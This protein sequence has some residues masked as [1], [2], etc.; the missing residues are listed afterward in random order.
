MANKYIYNIDD[1]M[2]NEL[3]GDIYKLYNMPEIVNYVHNG[4]PIPNKYKKLL[5]RNISSIYSNING[6]ISLQNLLSNTLKYCF[7]KPT[8]KN[9][10][11]TKQ[12]KETIMRIKIN[13]N[14]IKQTTPNS[15]D[16]LIKEKEI[17]MFNK[18]I[19][20]SNN[21]IENNNSIKTKYVNVVE[22]SYNIL[23]RKDN[24]PKY[25]YIEICNR[26][27]VKINFEEHFIRDYNNERITVKDGVIKK[28]FTNEID[29]EDAMI[30]RQQF[31]KKSFYVPPC[32]RKDEI[33]E[34]IKEEQEDIIEESQEDKNIIKQ[35]NT[36]INLII[37][38]NVIN[39]P[40]GIWNNKPKIITETENNISININ[41]DNNTNQEN[42]DEHDDDDWS[43]Y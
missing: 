8:N 13:I 35:E 9:T 5:E 14:Q 21:A 19:D 42:N 28:E 37:P 10:Q 6:Y 4:R 15:P 38:T 32:F 7:T 24:F 33:K 30:Y 41:Q 39:K 16:I 34:E 17:G 26:L 27:G 43:K 25:F 23:L 12:L 40:L 31:K 36:D 22:T 20:E 2:L 3:A 29:K 18:K 1:S 11:E